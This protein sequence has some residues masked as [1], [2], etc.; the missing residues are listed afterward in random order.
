MVRGL[1]R[2]EGRVLQADGLAQQH[3]GCGDEGAPT[4]AVGILLE[5]SPE[6]AT[7]GVPSE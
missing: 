1:S 2:A 3:P 7:A 4:G 6:G 5:L